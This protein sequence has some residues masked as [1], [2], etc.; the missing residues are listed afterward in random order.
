MATSSPHWNPILPWL[1]QCAPRGAIHKVELPADGA[2]DALIAVGLVIRD[3]P[4]TTSP[5]LVV[6][7]SGSGGRTLPS[8]SSIKPG[9]N[10]LR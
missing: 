1:T 5:A 2:G 4:Q 6:Q 3:F 8:A 9:T 7:W 10:S